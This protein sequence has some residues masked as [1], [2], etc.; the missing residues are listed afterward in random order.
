MKKYYTSGIYLIRNNIT[1]R[2]YIGQSKNIEKRNKDELFRKSINADF[3]ND[4]T[5]YGHAS[6]SCSI[7]ER[8]E[9]YDRN[10]MNERERF[11]IALYNSN[12]PLYGYNKTRGNYKLISKSKEQK[13]IK[14][15]SCIDI[16]YRKISCIETCETFDSY[17]EA[18]EKYGNLVFRSIYKQ[19]RRYDKLTFVFINEQS[20]L[21]KPDEKVIPIKIDINKMD[22][23]ETKTVVLKLPITML[24]RLDVYADS[25]SEK[26][27]LIKT[28]INDYLSKRE[29]RTR[30]AERQRKQ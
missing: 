10:L 8:I 17:I 1:G 20:D 13:D 11:Y 29:A 24:E 12:D 25:D 21:H 6:F 14:S 15:T 30:R 19:N 26:K 7:I 27:F 2:V 16:R 5:T 18:Y 22:A 23:V 28:A 3:V 4:V 9:S